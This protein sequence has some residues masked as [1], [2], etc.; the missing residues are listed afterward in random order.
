MVK[1]GQELYK[2]KKFKEAKDKFEAAKAA[3]PS[4]KEVWD[5]LKKILEYI[6]D[7]IAK[8]QQEFRKGEKHEHKDKD[9]HEKSGGD[10]PEAFDKAHHQYKKAKKHFKEAADADPL[11][12]EAKK[13]HK[14]AAAMAE[15]SKL[16]AEGV[17][18]FKQGRFKEALAKFNKAAKSHPGDKE[19]NEWVEKTKY[20]LKSVIMEVSGDPATFTPSRF[21]SAFATAL[22]VTAEQVRI[23]VMG[24]S[25]RLLASA[26]RALKLYVSVEDYKHDLLQVVS[27]H[28]FKAVMQS[29]GY[30]VLAVLDPDK[31]TQAPRP[32][33][34]ALSTPA[35]HPATPSNQQQA[36]AL[37][38]RGIKHFAEGDYK[39]AQAQFA[40]AAKLDPRNEEAAQWLRKT[41]AKRVAPLLISQGV[42]LYRNGLYQQAQTKFTA[43]QEADPLNSD[44]ALWLS[45]CHTRLAQPAVVPLAPAPI[46]PTAAPPPPPAA[47]PSSVHPG[48]ERRLKRL[49]EEVFK[50]KSEDT[51]VPVV[52]RPLPKVG[53]LQDQVS[54]TF[55]TPPAADTS[56]HISGGTMS[57]NAAKHSGFVPWKGDGI[58]GQGEPL[59]NE[60]K[61]TGGK[62]ENQLVE[63]LADDVMLNSGGRVLS[64]LQLTGMDTVVPL[65]ENEIHKAAEN[66]IEIPG[67]PHFSTFF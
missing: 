46:A 32:A 59:D 17:E 61:D 24:S 19:V 62:S 13:W 52:E 28:A 33:P 50:K 5:W 67:V 54:R 3:D 8:G 36:Q 34:R 1:E 21:K 51:R 43:A 2:D 16:L 30:P 60:G 66:S 12:A 37:V 47:A 38:T 35:P 57:I 4:N 27:S 25:R 58:L 18:L 39:P 31:T 6:A 55:F 41:I 22:G 20:M 40:A 10:T 42:A 64:E 26:N 63:K 14:K 49:E 7:L 11:D 45:K 65:G 48:V 56:S 23:L 9:E 29:S 15:V 44:A 53:G